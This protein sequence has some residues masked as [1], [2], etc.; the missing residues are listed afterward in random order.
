MGKR[1]ADPEEDETQRPKRND[2]KSTP[3][4]FP[5]TLNTG[6]SS[7][8]SAPKKPAAVNA[9]KHLIKGLKTVNC[10][11]VQEALAGMGASGVPKVLA[12]HQHFIAS[13]L[14]PFL[15]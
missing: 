3:V 13:K 2:S 10:A 7:S 11:M 9:D 8:S 6:S 1:K 14:T 15:N 5:P 4:Y 12:L